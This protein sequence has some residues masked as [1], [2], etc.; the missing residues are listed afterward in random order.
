MY[1]VCFGYSSALS[2]GKSPESLESL[3]PLES[4]LWSSFELAQCDSQ[5]ESLNVTLDLNVVQGNSR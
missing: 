4:P 1:I 5:I 3:S 2:I